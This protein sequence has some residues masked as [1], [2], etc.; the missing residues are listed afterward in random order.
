MDNDILAPD[1]NDEDVIDVTKLRESV[2]KNI[3]ASA[4]YQKKV[5]DKTRIKARKYKNGDLVLVKIQSQS[6]DGQSRKLLPCFKG[7]FQ[8]KK[9][10][11]HDRYEATDL[12]GSQR[13]SKI[14]NGVAAAE[15]LKPWINIDDLNIGINNY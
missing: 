7:P 12:R 14:Y 3:K 11:E 9:V 10:L 2:S 13:S 15:N 5:F 8:I 4:D 6:N 1:L